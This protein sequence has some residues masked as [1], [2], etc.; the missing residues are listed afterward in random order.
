[1]ASTRRRL[2]RS[3]ALV[4]V[5]ALLSVSAVPALAEDKV[6]FVIEDSRVA[7]SSG[8]TR[9]TRSDIYWTV[10]DSG[11]KGAVYG[12]APDGSVRGVLN[13][14]TT[15]VDVEAVA[16]FDD[17]LYVADIGDNGSKRRFVSVYFF[18][19]PRPNNQTVTYRSYDFSYPDGPHDAETLL[20]DGDGR[21]YIVTKGIKGG[22]YA[23]PEAPARLGTNTLERIAD[24]PPF[25]TDGVFLPGG[26]RIA[27]RTYVSVEVLDSSSY[28]VVARAATPPQPQGES[29]AVSLDGRSLLVGSEGK[30]SQV[31]QLPVPTKVG[32]APSAGSSPPPT[33]SPSPSRSASTTGDDTADEGDSGPGPSRSGTLLAL[34]L[35]ALV[36]LIAGVVV[37]VR[38]E[39]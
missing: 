21:L 33:A 18:N 4:W 31:F 26:D 37:A 22:I 6:A 28:Q 2:L 13:F 7:E 29:I 3:G 20:V 11:D 15:P 24:A 14:R 35:S 32:K 12:I 17:R 27:L 5:L 23:A 1:M 8:L 34:A 19:N 25:V 38:R 36:A 39:T 16:M 9:D 30:R 10:N